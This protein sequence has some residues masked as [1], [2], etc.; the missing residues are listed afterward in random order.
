MHF[1]FYS[2]TS[3]Q[4]GDRQKKSCLQFWLSRKRS[5][6]RPLGF[7]RDIDTCA[8]LFAF[9]LRIERQAFILL[10][11]YMG[12]R[13]TIYS[14]NVLNFRYIQENFSEIFSDIDTTYATGTGVARSLP[15]VKVIVILGYLDI[16]I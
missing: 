5:V 6:A 4:L 7:Q 10:I 14:G 12:R 11:N 8:T 1:S 2:T 13:L 15:P 9:I 3:V 16:S